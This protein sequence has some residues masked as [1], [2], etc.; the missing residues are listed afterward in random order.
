MKYQSSPKLLLFDF[1]ET[2]IKSKSTV[3]L[4]LKI[5]WVAPLTLLV[6]SSLYNKLQKGLVPL[7][8]FYLCCC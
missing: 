1:K 3:E 6:V 8:G 5:C 4:F 2:V 7:M